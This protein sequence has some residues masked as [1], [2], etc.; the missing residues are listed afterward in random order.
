MELHRV[1]DTD[2]SFVREHHPWIIP[3]L[4]EAQW[5][6]EA[7][8]FCQCGHAIR[9]KDRDIAG[10]VGADLFKGGG[11]EA[12]AGHGLHPQAQHRRVVGRLRIPGQVGPHER[13]ARPEPVRDGGEEAGARVR[14]EQELG[15][16]QAGGPVERG[17]LRQRLDHAGMEAAAVGEALA[18][19][20]FAAGGDHLRGRIQGEEG[21][22]REASRQMTDLGAGARAD[23]QH[24]GI[25]RQG[26]E[27]D[28]DQEQQAVADRGH[29]HSACVVAGGLLVEEGV[30]FVLLHRGFRG[31]LIPPYTGRQVP[32]GVASPSGS[33]AAP[34]VTTPGRRAP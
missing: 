24:M 30:E 17:L 14:I 34:T 19:R 22:A 5:R 3:R 32:R 4:V 10:V 9:R 7:A 25:V 16:Q 13:A 12:G 2:A 11:V 18:Q 23:A 1:E 29:A 26:G 33:D 20:A 21:P 31:G 6:R 28:V 15:D 8:G 27:H